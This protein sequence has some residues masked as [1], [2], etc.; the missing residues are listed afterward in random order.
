M[1]T[2][3][4]A[5]NV[6]NSL[7][8]NQLLDFLKFFADDNTLAL[9]ESEIIANDPNRKHYDSFQDIL[10]EIDWESDDE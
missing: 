10:N 5:V 7:N 1:S 6:F 3:E 4:L 9:A 8:E 2:K